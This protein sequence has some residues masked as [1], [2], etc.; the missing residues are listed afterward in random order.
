[1]LNLTEHKPEINNICRSLPV[2]RLGIFGSA[3][4]DKFSSDS[5]IDILVL[6]DS[7]E[8]ID[9]F[10]NYFTLKERLEKIFKHEVDLVIDKTFKNPVF[11]RSVENSRLTI[12]ER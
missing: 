3:L 5:D 4:T 6:F 10:D 12:Y 9:Y 7:D 2:K 11:N 8:N 1:M